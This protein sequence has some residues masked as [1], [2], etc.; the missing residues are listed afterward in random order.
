MVT[1]DGNIN[2]NSGGDY[3]LKVKGN[4][5]SKIEGS[6]RETIEGSKTSDTTMGVIHRGQNVII[7]GSTVHV[8][9]HP[10]DLN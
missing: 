3:N 4:Y 9:G 6:K 10:I 1:V 7:E 2:V 5:I 8:I